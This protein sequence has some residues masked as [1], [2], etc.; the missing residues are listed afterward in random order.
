MGP[1][2]CLRNGLGGEEGGGIQLYFL[3]SP[4]CPGPSNHLATVHTVQSLYTVHHL[5]YI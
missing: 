2:M 3:L 4:L 5:A 1:M